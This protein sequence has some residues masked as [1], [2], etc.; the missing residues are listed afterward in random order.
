M[1]EVK[2][3]AWRRRKPGNLIGVILENLLFY[4]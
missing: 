1:N 2:N 3:I 4:R